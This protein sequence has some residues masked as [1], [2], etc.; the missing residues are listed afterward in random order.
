M[1]KDMQRV[2][3][4]L[5]YILGSFS[6]IASGFC[7][8]KKEEYITILAS[9]ATATLTKNFAEIGSQWAIDD[10][11][12]TEAMK[13]A[14]NNYNIAFITFAIIAALLLVSALI[15]TVIRKKR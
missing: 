14:V 11:A 15:I 1:K 3:M 12:K 8:V 9:D 10:L 4:F 13:V 2:L 6:I 7:Y 5:L